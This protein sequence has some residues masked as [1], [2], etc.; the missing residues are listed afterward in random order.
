MQTASNLTYGDNMRDDDNL[1]PAADWQTAYR[2][3]NDAEYEIY[4]AAA[5]SLG[6]QIKTYDEW[7]N[8]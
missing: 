1:L 3:T 7:L 4:V 5:E 6:W 2:G 8:S